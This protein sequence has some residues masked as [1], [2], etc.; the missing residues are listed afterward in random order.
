[1]VAALRALPLVSYRRRDVLL[2]GIP[3]YNLGLFGQTLWRLTYLPYRDWPPRPDEA[4]RWRQL[5][6]P[7]RPGALLYVER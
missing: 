2:M 4:A 6:H 5:R 3:L 7:S 1:V